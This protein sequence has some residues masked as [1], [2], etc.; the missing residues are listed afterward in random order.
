MFVEKGT[1]SEDLAFS[2]H[3]ESTI[4]PVRRFVM[5]EIMTVKE[6]ARYLKMK[7][8]TIYRCAQEGRLP[9]IKIRGQWRFDKNRID[10]MINQGDANRI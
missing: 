9:G 4:V 6:L 3:P 10:E 2:L 7:E 5:A 8:V 1:L